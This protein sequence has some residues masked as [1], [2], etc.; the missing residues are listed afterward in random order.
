LD[1]TQLHDDFDPD[2]RLLERAVD[3]AAD[4][5]VGFEANEWQAVQRRGWNAL[6]PGSLSQMFACRDAGG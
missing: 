4:H 2:T 1:R 5:S 3:Q 6:P